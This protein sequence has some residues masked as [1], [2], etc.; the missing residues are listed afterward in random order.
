MGSITLSDR[1]RRRAEV[2]SRT[3]AGLLSNEQAARLL[4]VSLRHLRRLRTRFGAE[5]L[6]S[7]IHANTGREP[8][9][10]TAS[11]VHQKLSELVG[12]GGTYHDFNTTHLQELLG[13][14]EGIQIG[15]STLD[16]LL[17]QDGIR[18]RRRGRARRVFGRRECCAR[19]GEMLLTD[20][21]LHEWLEGRNPEHPKMCLMGSIDD[22]TGHAVSLRFWPTEC[23][24]GY[25]YMARQVTTEHG[26]PMSFYHDRHT[27]LVSPKEPTIE[28]ELAGREPMS[29]WQAILALLGA[30]PIQALTPQAKGRIERLWRTLQDRLVKEMRLAGISSIEQANAFL[31]ES[32][33]IERFNARFGREARD[34]EAAWVRPEEPGLDLPFYFAAKQERVVKADHTLSFHGTTLQIER[35]RG[36]RSLAGTRVMVHITPEGERFLYAGRERLACEL[37]NTTAP[38][39]A[40]APEPAGSSHLTPQQRQVGRRRQMAHLHAGVAA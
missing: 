33:F 13:E 12:R 24:A 38:K 7:V 14:R 39:P 31:S 17:T 37:L 27:M 28:D 30:E 15:R 32:G 9:N 21:S 40:P 2:L 16:R 6:A 4:G 20:G 22:A 35:K 3:G 29:Q 1:Q 11:G 26:I 10:K 23:Q 25:I 8:A 5:G 34:P 18:K 19:A 36:E